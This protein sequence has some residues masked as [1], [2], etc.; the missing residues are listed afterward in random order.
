MFREFNAKGLITKEELLIQA[1]SEENYDTALILIAQGANFHLARISYKKLTSMLESMN[2]TNNPW[3][4]EAIENY[5]VQNIEV[6]EEDSGNTPLHAVAETNY[7]QSLKFLLSNGASATQFMKNK[8]T[9][10]ILV[11]NLSLHQNI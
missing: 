4:R 10:V 1:I 3:I 2:L 11:E 9:N 6:K 7:E 5:L 8:D